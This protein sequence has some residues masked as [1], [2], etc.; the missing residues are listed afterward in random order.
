MRVNIKTDEYFEELLREED[1][2]LIFLNEL[3]DKAIE[4]KGK[5]FPGVKNGY[6]LYHFNR[7]N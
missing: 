5:D 1:K 3:L 6:G 2:H 4:E 7:S